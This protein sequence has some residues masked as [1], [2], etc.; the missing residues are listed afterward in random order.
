MPTRRSGTT[1]TSWQPSRVVA[2]KRPAPASFLDVAHVGSTTGYVYGYYRN[3]EHEPAG[4]TAAEGLGR[5]GKLAGCLQQ[6]RAHG[7]YQDQ[8]L[9]VDG[10]F[11]PLRSRGGATGG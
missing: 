2:S 7:R 4:E 9:P 6:R 10:L 5:A 11:C 3:S 1:V 8:L